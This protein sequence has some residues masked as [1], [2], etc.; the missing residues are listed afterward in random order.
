MCM[1]QVEILPVS[2]V[3]IACVFVGCELCV[4]MWY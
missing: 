4:V 1:M 3:A 2:A